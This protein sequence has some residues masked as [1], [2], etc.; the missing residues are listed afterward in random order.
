M[1]GVQTCALPIS[2]DLEKMEKAL[3]YVEGK[4]REGKRAERENRAAYL[5][6]IDGMLAGMDWETGQRALPMN[7]CFLTCFLISCNRR[8][9]VAERLTHWHHLS[10]CD[11]FPIYDIRMDH[12]CPKKPRSL[13]YKHLSSVHSLSLQ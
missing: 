1:T 9:V 8:R 3:K 5:K 13:P 7:S 11:S 4:I 6:E 2:Y 12:N 10:H